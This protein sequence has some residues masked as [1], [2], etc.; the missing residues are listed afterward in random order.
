MAPFVALQQ[1]SFDA[2][3]GAAAD[4]GVAPSV[5]LFLGL[6]GVAGLVAQS[7]VYPLD[8]VRRRMQV[9]SVATNAAPAAAGKAAAGA[10]AGAGANAAGKAEARGVFVQT[11]TWLALRS[12]VR[13]E[14]LGCLFRGM[15]PTFLKVLPAVGV[16]VTV[17][18]AVLGRLEQDDDD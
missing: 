6:G 9:A 16:S 5:P 14:G 7:V 3:K 8:V 15:V 12:M 17:R 18:D 1:A 11:Y 4:A 10:G 2:L 13:E